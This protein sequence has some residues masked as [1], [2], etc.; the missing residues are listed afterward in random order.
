MCGVQGHKS[1]A[2]PNKDKG[3]K[4]GQTGHFARACLQSNEDPREGEGRVSVIVAGTS[5]SDVPPPSSSHALA[6]HDGAPQDLSAD[7]SMGNHPSVRGISIS[8][9]VMTSLKMASW[10]SV[11]KSAFASLFHP[12]CFSPFFLSHETKRDC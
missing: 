6:P 7:P 5:G 12:Y 3:R 4:C 8:G 1:S 2:C 11:G 9:Y 10:T